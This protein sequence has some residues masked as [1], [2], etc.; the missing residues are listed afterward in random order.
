MPPNTLPATIMN[1]TVSLLITLSAN[2]TMGFRDIGPFNIDIN[3]LLFHIQFDIDN[4]PWR[5]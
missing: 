4:F 5:L 3:T 1:L 2:R